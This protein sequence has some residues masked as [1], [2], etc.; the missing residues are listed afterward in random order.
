[1]TVSNTVVK[2]VY[3]GN[4]STTVFPYTFALNTDDG[5]YVQ[6]LI[7]DEAGVETDVTQFATIDTNIRTVTYPN[8][9]TPLPAG[10][11][12]VL[13][14]I[15]PYTQE[16]NLESQGPFYAEDIEAELDRIVMMVQQ[17]KEVTDRCVKA[18][19]SSSLVISEM[20]IQEIY[21]AR[22]DAETAAV[23]AGGSAAAAASSANSAATN[24]TT[25]FNAAIDAASSAADADTSAA[26]AANSAANA[27]TSAGQAAAAAQSAQSLIE[28]SAYDEDVTYQP[29]ETA[30]LPDG[31]VYRCITESTGEYPAT[32]SKWVS[33]ATTVFHT[34]EYNASG[35][36]VPLLHPQASQF[37]GINENG[38]IYPKLY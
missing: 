35:N 1:M 27:D 10:R 13:K 38:N 9:G 37:F 36:L 16:L 25:A 24:A 34:F 20:T 12:I 5:Q 30:M 19:A 26:H 28:T 18:S 33:V 29:G 32:S 6:V 4:G 8:A 15:I 31:A 22:D 11:K 17:I 2:N 7:T 23:A 14:R 3:A 21:Q